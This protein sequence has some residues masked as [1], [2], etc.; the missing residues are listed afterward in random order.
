MG[1]DPID[2]FDDFFDQALQKDT[3][4]RLYTGE[5]ALGIAFGTLI[6]NVV[7]GQNDDLIID[8]KVDNILLGGNGDDTF[9]LGAG[10]FDSV[11]GGNGHN[12]IDLSDFSSHDV[13][14]IQFEADPEWSWLLTSD[15]FSVQFNN[16]Q[17]IGFADSDNNWLLA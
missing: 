14:I 3:A 2:D 8:N 7:G 15:D 11:D 4:D 17:E 16:I 10:G 5:K 9:E 12:I 13:N 1:W 6:E